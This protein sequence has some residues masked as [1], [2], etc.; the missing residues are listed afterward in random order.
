[1]S[2]IRPWW[3]PAVWR[4]SAFPETNVRTYVRYGDDE[5]GVWFISLD[6]ARLAAVLIGRA[7]WHLDYH[8]AQM[9]VGRTSGRVRYESRRFGRRA[10]GARIEAEID[11]PRRPR[12]RRCPARSTIS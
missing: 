3:S 9:H 5:P 8:W 11:E 2:G 1:M 4:L 7:G 6:A 10:A 12:A